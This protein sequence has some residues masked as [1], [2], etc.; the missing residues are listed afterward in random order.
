VLSA[1]VVGAV[2]P[3][4]EYLVH[5]STRRTIGHT[6]PGLFVLCLPLSLLTL[7][8]WHRLVAPAWAPLLTGRRTP[9]FGFRPLPRLGLVALSALAGS[10]SH[11]VWDAF[12]HDGGL[13]VNRVGLLQATLPGTGVHVY[14]LLQHASSVGGAVYLAVWAHRHLGPAGLRVP[15]AALV[16]AAAVGVTAGAGAAANAFVH[17]VS[18]PGP[19]SS[20][21]AAAAVGGMAAG[22][23]AVLVVSTMLRWRARRPVPTGCPLAARSRPGPRTGARVTPVGR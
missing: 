1:L 7:W 23:V 5:L 15:A 6:L 4:L 20:V 18:G 3:D 17:W 11:L 10:L 9:W 13:V 8:A 14:S 22:T 12:T 21:L 16:P 2:A 19:L